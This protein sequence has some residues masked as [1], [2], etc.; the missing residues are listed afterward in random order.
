MMRG[1]VKGREGG[2]SRGEHKAG[3]RRFMDYESM[4]KSWMGCYGNGAKV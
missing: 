1:R 3:L 4:S 2:G